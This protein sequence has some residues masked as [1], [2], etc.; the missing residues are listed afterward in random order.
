MWYLVVTL[1]LSTGGFKHDALG[2][3]DTEQECVSEL[4]QSIRAVSPV[5]TLNCLPSWHNITKITI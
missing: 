2:S 4:R 5:E 3:F 1:T